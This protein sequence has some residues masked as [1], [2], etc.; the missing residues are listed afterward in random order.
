MDKAFDRLLVRGGNTL[1]GVVRMEGAK[2]AAL[3]VLAACLLAD[4]ESRILGVPELDDVGTMCSVLRRLGGAVSRTAADEVVVRFDGIRTSEAPQDLVRKMRASVLVMGPLLAR[5][6]LARACLPGGCAIGARPIDLHLK[7]FALMGAAVTCDRGFVEVSAP[8]LKGTRIY[9]DYP[10]VGATENLM[11]AASLAEGFTCID[12]AAEEPEVVDLAN[13]LCCMGARVTGAGTKMIRIEGCDSLRPT[14]YSIIPDRIEAGTFMTAAAIAGGDVL[15]QNVVVEH[16]K[17]IIAKLLDAGCEVSEDPEG[18]IR[19]VGPDRPRATDV[20]TLPY[21]GFPTDMQ[22]QMMALL[23]VAGG[24]SMV[25]ETVFENRFMHVDEFKR[26]GANIHVD[27]RTAVVR[28]VDHLTGAV[29]R[30]TDLRA[31]AAL[32]IAGLRSH[33]TTEILG[34]QHLDRGYSDF[35]GK[36]RSIGAEVVRAREAA[37]EAFLESAATRRLD[38]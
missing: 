17:P 33:G 28:G 11:M 6:G 15:V 19:V 1:R 30:A 8:R 31:G 36:M 37:T 32:L 3:P 14:T 4:G 10:S 25:T 9:L 21:P 20:R 2:N 35:A 12:N 24:V 34:V 5:T 18:S 26:M 22:P 7:G 38:L 29:V 27:G 23:S 13:F 16:V